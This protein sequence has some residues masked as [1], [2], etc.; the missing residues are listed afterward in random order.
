MSEQAWCAQ[1]DARSAVEECFRMLASRGNAVRCI[2]DKIVH[3]ELR[4]AD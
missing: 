3:S 1:A 4:V 2:L